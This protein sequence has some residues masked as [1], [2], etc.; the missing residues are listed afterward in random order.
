MISEAVNVIKELKR[1][2]LVKDELGNHYIYSDRNRQYERIPKNIKFERRICNI[3]S[4]AKVVQAEYNSS[5]A[6][7]QCVIFEED[8]AT[9]FTDEDLKDDQ[10]KWIF[11]RKFTNLWKIVS[12]LC[13]SDPLKHKDLLDKLESVKNSVVDFEN[14][15]QVLSKL[16]VNKK[17]SFASSPVFEDGEQ[18]GSY[19]WEQKIDASGA[20][21]KARCPSCIRFKGKIVRGS[22]STYEFTVNLVPVIDSERGVLLFKIFMPTIDMVLDQVREDEQSDFIKLIGD[23]A[24]HILILRN[25]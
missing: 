20:T 9:F 6:P 16:R 2:E 17:I 15:Y 14:L 18:S 10:N 8:G 22:D 19:E 25:Y 13:K 21:E 23:I 3:E 7:K 24:N 1:P 5:V 12:E 4:F 11:C